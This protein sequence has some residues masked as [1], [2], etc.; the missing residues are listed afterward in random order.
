[1]KSVRLL[2][3]SLL[4]VAAAQFAQSATLV[5]ST[6][7]VKTFGHIPLSFEPNRGQTNPEARFV[8][9]GQGY[10][11]FL[12]PSEAVLSLQSLQKEDVLHHPIKDDKAVSAV[13]RLQ[14]LNANVSTAIS[15]RDQLPGYSNYFIG[16]DQSKWLTRIPQYAKIEYSQIY[17]GIDLLYYGNQRQLEY[18]FIV[19]PGADP[20]AIAFQ[21]QGSDKVEV[22]NQGQLTIHLQNTALDLQKPIVYQQINGERREVAANY[23]MQHDGR[24]GFALGAYDSRLPL[25]IDPI[26]TYSSYLGGTSTDAANAVAV[27]T[28][29]SAYITGQTTSM[30]FPVVGAYQA[31]NHGLNAFLTKMSPDGT[32]V[33]FS[34]FLGGT[35]INCGG[36]RG[37]SIALNAINEPFVAGRAFSTDFPVTFKGY[38]RTGGGCS[39]GGGGGSGFV[40]HFSA[41]GTT[42]KYSTYFGGL[43]GN[44]PTNILSITVSQT[45]NNAYITGYD[46]TGTLATTGAFQTTL[47]AGGDQGAF[48]TKFTTDGAHLLFSTYVRATTAGTVIGNSIA[49]D[50]NGNSY[51]T[52]AA[53]TTS[54]P[55]TRGAFQKTFGGGISDAF[56][57]KVN[58]TGA[59]LIYSSYLG[60]SDTTQLE[61]GSQIIVEFTF[62]AYVVGTTGSTNFPTTLGTLQ[63]AYPGGATSAFV[64]RVASDGT[65]LNF[66][67]FLGGTQ[68]STG[69]GIGYTPGCKSPCNLVVYGNTNS[70]DFPTHNPMQTTG[71]LF[72]TTLDG[73]GVTIPGYSTLLGSPSG[74]T[75][76][77]LATDANLRAFITGT[78]TS[79]SYPTTAGALETSYAGGSSDGFISKVAMSSDL[80]VTQTASPIP[81]IIGQNLTYTITVTDNGPDNG[82]GL[83]LANAVPAGTTFVSITPSAGTCNP[84]PGQTGTAHCVLPSLNSATGQNTWTITWVLNVTG[85]SGQVIKNR[86]SVIEISPD[87]NAA[88]NANTLNVKIQ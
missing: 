72:L 51:I 41:D 55:L 48:V 78:T 63:A 45:S 88:N 34:T 52:G 75:A 58:T 80:A 71:D 21:V 66:S 17:S 28:T 44:L 69:V 3:V 85:I 82:V 4:L 74:D 83:A 62:G 5:P 15:G 23:V 32:S 50:R 87:P 57:T 16:K 13:L 36:D 47:D 46:Q 1:M 38:Q 77:G 18:D 35:D 49:L 11:L 56:V 86:A 67:T 37:N 20:N 14:L 8:A 79:L 54:L 31:T 73:F 19:A 64:A 7:T 29:G 2:V 42:L 84:P 27:D 76:T 12:T 81:A 10:S 39:G 65:R 33:V 43:V 26:L 59:G 9:R 40:T 6:A 68:G 60:G 25:V 70:T 30:D 61:Y 22:G 53:E 24:I